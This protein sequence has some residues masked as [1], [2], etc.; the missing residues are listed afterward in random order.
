MYIESVPNRSS[1]PAILLR[2][3]YRDAGKIKKRTLANLTNWPTELVEGLRTLLKGGTAIAPG[4][5]PIVVRRSLPHGAVA[6]ALGTLRAIGLDRMLG[7]A[8]DRCRELVIAMVVNRIVAPASKAATARMLDGETAA[9]SL[10]AL[11]E[12]GAVDED[13]L[14]KALDWLG[15][16][17]QAIEKSLARKHLKDGALVL[18]D[19]SSSYME[20]RC[21]RL[22]RF[23][24]NRDGKKG[25]LQIVYGLLCS[26][27]GTPIAVEVFEGNTSDPKTLAV[28]VDKLKQRFALKHIVLVGDRGMITQ[29]RID[30]ELKP[31]ASIGSP[32]CAPPPSGHW[33][34]AERCRCRCSISVIWPPSACPTFPANGSWCA[35]TAIWPANARASART[36]SPPPSA[37]WPPSP[38]PPAASASRYEAK[39][40][41]A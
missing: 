36:C 8:G 7:T 27:D 32:R 3:S 10:A 23:G 12:I 14:Y 41:S 30:Q 38:K 19:V 31:A 28:H 25:K 24:Y 35:A 16:R 4:T 34:K 2:E 20:G 40:R 6:T 13:E 37:I 18:Y 15:E 5:A 9:S 33:P 11:L 39:P 29:A 26:A 21:C 22:A 1:P 17:Q